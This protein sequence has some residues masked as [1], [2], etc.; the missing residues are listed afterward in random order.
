MRDAMEKTGRK[1][2]LRGETVDCRAE[3]YNR[4]LVT[5]K[6]NLNGVAKLERGRWTIKGHEVI[7]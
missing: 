3:R 4:Q 6:N 2:E 5:A 1:K 7:G